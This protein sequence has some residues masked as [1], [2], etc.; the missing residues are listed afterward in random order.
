MQKVIPGTLR[1]WS[2]Q[3]LAVWDRLQTEG[4]LYVDPAHPEFLPDAPEWRSSYDWLCEQMAAR[5]EGYA[6]HYPW[7]AW[8]NCAL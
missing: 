8:L 2:I 6:G 7:W 3:P 4:E 5:T 1:L